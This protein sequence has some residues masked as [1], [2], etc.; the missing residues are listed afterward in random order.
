MRAEVFGN[1]PI[2]E[3]F[4]FPHFYF[5]HSWASACAACIVLCGTQ[6]LCITPALNHAGLSVCSFNA[7]REY[8]QGGPK[9]GLQEEQNVWM[10]RV[11]LYT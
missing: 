5:R 2:R 3:F 10:Q 7:G 6:D 1:T 4:N 8:L 9:P 11:Y